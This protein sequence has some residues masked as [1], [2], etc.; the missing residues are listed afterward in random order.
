LE[1]EE[2]TRLK[3]RAL[4]LKKETEEAMEDGGSSEAAFLRFLSDVA[5]VRG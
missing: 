3:K 4:Q 1:S 5:N 2:G